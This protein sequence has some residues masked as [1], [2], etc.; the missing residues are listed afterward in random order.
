MNIVTA[1]TDKTVQVYARVITSGDYV[2][3]LWHEFAN[4]Y[5]EETVAGTVVDKKLQLVLPFEFLEKRFYYLR[6]FYDDVEVYRGKIFC[7]DASDTSNF[8]M[9][10]DFYTEP[11]KEPTTYQPK[12]DYYTAHLLFVEDGVNRLEMQNSE[13]IDLQ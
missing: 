2:C 12:G 13:F 1:G 5:F 4:E 11:T 8:K 3:Q 7:T 10:E 6:V 9:L